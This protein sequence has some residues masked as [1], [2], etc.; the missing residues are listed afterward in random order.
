MADP[1]TITTSVLALVKICIKGFNLV[2]EYSSE[3][4]RAD[5]KI[6]QLS[7]Q[8]SSLKDVLEE[9]HGLYN[10]D[11]N[12]TDSKKRDNGEGSDSIDA[13]K[14]RARL[15]DSENQFRILIEKLQPFLALGQTSSPNKMSIQSRISVTWSRDEIETLRDYIREERES[16][17]AFISTR[18]HVMIYERHKRE[19]GSQK[20]HDM[21]SKPGRVES[22]IGDEKFSSNDKLVNIAAD[23]QHWHANSSQ[24]Q[25]PSSNSS[26][27]PVSPQIPKSGSPRVSKWLRR[28]VKKE[29]PSTG[30]SGTVP[31]TTATGSTGITLVESYEEALPTEKDFR[32]PYGNLTAADVRNL[33][34]QFRSA[35][36]LHR[37]ILAMK[38]ADKSYGHIAAA[39]V[40]ERDAILE[41]IVQTLQ[42]WDPRSAFVGA[43]EQQQ[44]KFM[45]DTVPKV[46]QNMKQVRGQVGAL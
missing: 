9:M 13:A 46:V 16:I 44:I 15:A 11:K 43:L 34:D 27:A 5:L 2:H 25:S 30:S 8:C 26:A 3:L 1:I 41:I 6:Q 14:V 40:A 45:L 4:Q 10:L 20:S 35:L 24:G 33:K 18:S 37:E 7:R 19:S 32:D 29:E 38:F 22:V 21:P 31:L 23:I 28:T 39:K 17:I 42:D 36:V 12:K